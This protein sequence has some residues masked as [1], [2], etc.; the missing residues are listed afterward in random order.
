MS[1]ELCYELLIMS[2]VM[3]YEFHFYVVK[4]LCFKVL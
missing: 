3:N 2:Y 4:Y 1:Y